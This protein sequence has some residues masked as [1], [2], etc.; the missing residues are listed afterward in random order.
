MSP[1]NTAPVAESVDIAGVRVDSFTEASLVDHVLEMAKSDGVDVAVGVNAHVCNLARKDPRFRRL[2]DDGSTYADGQSVVW[3]AKLLGG[4]LPGR[5][6]T[7]DIA[8]PV[9]RAA[10]DADIPVYFFGAAE[11]VAERAAAILRAKIPGLRLRTHHGYVAADRIDEVLDDMRSHGTG[12]LFVGMGDPAQQLWID[13]HRDRLPPAVLT[14]GGLFDWLSGSNK[15]APAWMIR[16]GLEWLW[17][18]IIEPR[19]LAKR[20]LLGNPSFMAAVATQR[21]RGSRA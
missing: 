16:G 15:R 4:H 2:V 11:G 7:T 12:I 3:A 18:L 9:L 19:R 8:E 1:G 10:A 21:L 20:Y 14:C 13:A 6:A 5:L 17:R